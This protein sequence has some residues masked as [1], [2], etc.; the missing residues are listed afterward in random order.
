MRHFQNTWNL[1]RFQILRPSRGY[2]DFHRSTGGR[3]FSTPT[4]MAA[5]IRR[6]SCHKAHGPSN[7]IPGILR[8]LYPTYQVCLICR[9]LWEE[10]WLIENAR[11][12]LNPKRRGWRGQKL[13]FTKRKVMKRWMEDA[14]PRNLAKI[15]LLI[16]KQNGFLAQMS[17]LTNFLSLGNY[18]TVRLDKET[19]LKCAILVPENTLIWLITVWHYPNREIWI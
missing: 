7:P 14:S 15:I 8:Y 10:I 19:E 17:C 18:V 3:L 11:T 5:V 1:Q 12:N 4:E 9:L 16:E 6:L 13:S 2:R